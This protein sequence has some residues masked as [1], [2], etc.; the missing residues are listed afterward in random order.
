MLMKKQ[1]F[2]IIDNIK[3]SH[4]NMKFVDNL[5]LRYKLNIDLKISPNLILYCVSNS[6]S[7]LGFALSSK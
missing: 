1:Q 5:I 4:S 7:L 2:E 6:T 3:N